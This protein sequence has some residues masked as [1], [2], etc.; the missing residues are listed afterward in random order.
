MKKAINL[1]VLAG[2]GISQQEAIVPIAEAGFDGCFWVAQPEVSTKCIAASVRAA[3]LDIPFIHAP[4]KKID[5]V[6]VAGEE[7][8]QRMHDLIYWLQQCADA[9]IP[10]MVC[11]VW[12]KFAPVEPNPVGIDRFSELLRLAERLGIQVAFEN[13]EIG[14]FMTAI[15]THLWSSP[16]AGFCYDSGH[17][18]CYNGG[19][20]QLAEFGDKLLCVHL[21]DNMGQLGTELTS[22]D[23]SHMMPFDGKVDWDSVARRLKACNYH[24]DL[25]LEIKMANK[26]GRHTHDRYDSLSPREILA[27][28]RRK[29]EQFEKMMD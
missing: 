22:A 13:A 4:V 19:V 23:D 29:A 5:T 1:T 6:W 16:A 21:N 27:L 17:E 10:C 25:T 11:H 28:A 14:K 3:G 20:D 18:L 26:P 9:Q 8:R 24:G 2:R 12:T 7:G 15:R